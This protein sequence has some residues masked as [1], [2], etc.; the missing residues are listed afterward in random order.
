MYLPAFST[1]AS[2]L[3][4]SPHSL[5]LTVSLFIVAMAVGQL[6]YGPLSDAWG[7]R[8]PLIVGICIFS[9]GAVLCANAQSIRMLLVGRVVMAIGGSAGLVIARAVVRDQFHA[10]EA[11]R[12][13]ARLMTV[14]ALAPLLAPSIGSQLLLLGG[15]RLIFLFLC[16]LGVVAA[17]LVIFTLG[18]SHPRNSRNKR[19][20]LDMFGGARTLLAHREFAA[21]IIANGCA[22]GIIFAYVSSISS[23]FMLHYSVSPRIFPFLFGVN[24]IA[25][26]AGAQLARRLLVWHSPR[27]LLRRS[28]A[29]LS[30]CG[31][32]IAVVGVT[33]YGGLSLLCVLLFITLGATATAIPNIA[34]LAMAPFPRAAGQASSLLGTSQYGLGGIIGGLVSLSH[35]SSAA[36]MTLVMALASFLGLVAVRSTSADGT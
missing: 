12:V 23:V 26:I 36:A 18:E 28:F 20:L 35:S 1:V 10:N 32:V 31:G 15:W 29:T 9:L 33:G 6:V 8:L 4:A 11:A 5:S 2:E 16:G 34:G 27:R 22:F 25:V 24:A 19:A 30:V 13:F 14:Q 21:L 3:A 17:S 7:R